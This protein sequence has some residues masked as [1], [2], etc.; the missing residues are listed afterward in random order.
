M[1]RP[2][3]PVLSQP[4][5]VVFSCSAVQPRATSPGVVL[6]SFPCLRASFGAGPSGTPTSLMNLTYAYD[7]VG[8]ALTI[9]DANAGG[10]QTQTFTYDA[11]NRLSTT[12]ASGG[13]GGTY[14]QKTYLY[15]AVGNITS[16]TGDG[17]WPR[18]SGNQVL[19]LAPVCP[20]SATRSYEW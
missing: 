15:N 10:T 17:T 9:A 6:A 1:L 3:R 8:N 11:L 2:A 19:T 13:T 12:A 18:P 16:S 7:P 4:T 20:A 14:T 5:A